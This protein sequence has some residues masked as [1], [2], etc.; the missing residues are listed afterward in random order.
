MAATILPMCQGQRLMLRSALKVIV[1]LPGGEGRRVE[2]G[3]RCRGDRGGP[4]G[5]M[6]GEDDYSQLGEHGDG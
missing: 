4:G 1:A 6:R 2:G 3:R 5:P